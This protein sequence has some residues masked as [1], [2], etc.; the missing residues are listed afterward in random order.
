MVRTFRSA[1]FGE[2][3]FEPESVIDL[4]VGIPGFDDLR[5]LTIIA[6]QD[7]PALVFLQSLD[8]ADLCFLAVPVEQV[9]PD[10]ELHIA[11]EDLETLGASGTD[12]PLRALAVLSLAEGKAPTA[13]LLSPIVIHTG[14]MR[15]VQAIR[16]DNRYTC[17]E[18]IPCS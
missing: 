13:N 3:R 15:A 11:E 14:T 10:Y 18:A 2:I 17:Q 9:R 8:H 7:H 16:P 6:S 4:P 5:S 12:D 1:Y